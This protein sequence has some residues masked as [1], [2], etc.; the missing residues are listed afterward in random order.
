[1]DQIYQDFADC[2]KNQPIPKALRAAFDVSDTLSKLARQ[3]SRDLVIFEGQI[4][5]ILLNITK[6]GILYFNLI[7]KL[8]G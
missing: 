1:M 8:Q 2:A 5:K 4:D 3:I 7:L 6:S